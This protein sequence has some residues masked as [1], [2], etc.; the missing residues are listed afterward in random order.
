MFLPY[1]FFG[2]EIKLQGLVVVIIDDGM[3]DLNPRPLHWGI[4]V[5]NPSGLGDFTELEEVELRPSI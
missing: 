4:G 2:V 5:V 3:R 1:P